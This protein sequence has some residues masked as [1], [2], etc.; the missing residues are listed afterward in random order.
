M[1]LSA[2][3]ALVM[4]LL[5]SL[6]LI[7]CAGNTGESVDDNKSDDIDAL[8]EAEPI[9]I[10]VCVDDVDEL[11]AVF[12]RDFKEEDLLP[13]DALAGVIEDEWLKIG[14]FSAIFKGTEDL[15]AQ[16]RL[17]DAYFVLFAMK[18]ILH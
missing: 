4:G 5:C 6:A 18:D 12:A 10:K 11:H 14:T 3:R 1:S 15:C 8:V 2:A 13:I 17:D 7:G 9:G 16:D